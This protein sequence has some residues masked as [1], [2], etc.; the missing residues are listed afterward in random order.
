[1]P[2]NKHSFAGY[3]IFPVFTDILQDT[4]WKDV[5]LV[6]N[7]TGSNIATAVAVVRV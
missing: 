2:A 6:L 5:I 4:C 3:I 7:G 1:L